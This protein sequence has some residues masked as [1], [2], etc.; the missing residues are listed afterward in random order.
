[1]LI[2]RNHFDLAIVGGGPAGTSAAITA[3][4]AG[5]NVLL[6]EARQFPRHKVCGEFVSAEAL[7]VLRALLSHHPRPDALF[8]AT[9]A[10]DRVRLLLGKRSIEATISPPAL[11]IPRYVLDDSLWQAA[12]Q[13]AVDCRDNFEATAFEGNG[14]VTLRTTTAKITAKVL[15]VAAGRWSQFTSDRSSPPGS[16]WIGLKAHFRE[17][18]PAFSTDLYFFRH[19]Y[20]GVQPV[21]DDTVNACAMVRSD[22]ATSLPEV[23]GLHPALAARAESWEQVTENITT[24]PLIYRR[25]QPVRENVIFVGDAA[26]FIDPF[27]GDGI[28]IALRSGRLAAECLEKFFT[29]RQT[30]K[31]SVRAYE[32]E[33]SRRF[34]PLLSTASRVRSLLSLH[35]FAQAAAF[36]LLRLPGLL[37]FII[38]KTRRA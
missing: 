26:A 20:C 22:C 3:A 2:A 29:G 31:E 37:P 38:R 23:F 36:E 35:R 27:V 8:S 6:V 24:A 10:I 25:P 11:S 17:P 5:A 13:A 15:I 9:P 1:M 32:A 18:Q 7:G 21:A 33:Y 19:G 30:L 12:R 16:K 14:P 4:R 34:S 28:S